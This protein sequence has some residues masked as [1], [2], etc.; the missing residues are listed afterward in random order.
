MKAT[1]KPLYGHLSIGNDVFN[2]FSTNRNI[3]LL[4]AES[5]EKKRL[6]M[7][8]RAISHETEL[9]EFL[10]GYTN[11]RQIAILR[12]SEFQK[13]FYDFAPSL[14]FTTPMI[15]E[16]A[17]YTEE[18]FSPLAE[19]W[20][21]FHAITFKGI[22]LNNLF[23]PYEALEQKS[24]QERATTDGVTDLKTLP[25][26]KYT[27]EGSA[28]IDG[29][30]IAYTISIAQESLPPL[31]KDHT[32]T[33][34]ELN[35]FIRFSFDEPQDFSRITRYFLIAKS[36]ISLLTMQNNVDFETYLS[37][38]N[39]DGTYYRTANC[40]IYD[41]YEN[42]ATRNQYRVIP[43]KT[44]RE[45]IPA[46]LENIAAGKYEALFTILPDDNRRL[47]MISITNIQDLC[48]ALEVAYKWGKNQR[49]KDNIIV[50][51]RKEAAKAAIAALQKEYPEI[52]LK[53]ETTIEKTFE[54]LDFIVKSKIFTLYEENQR[55]IDT[56]AK[57]HNWETLTA[58]RISEFTSI[59]NKKT[60]AGTFEWG[61][62]AE[63]YPLLYALAYTCALK[64]AGISEETLHQLIWRLF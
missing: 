3:L 31:G 9:P 56:L 18:F 43:I 29:Q 27:M 45:Q 40:R 47:E 35:T 59:R 11:A 60:H 41:I 23:T 37:Q 22:N 58:E 49:K 63:I 44:I 55:I 20:N 54:Y 28:T 61:A 6:D 2:Y 5:D 12:S 52:A 15:V 14:A 33:L 10:F 1:S 42:Y 24:M 53:Q 39:A 13:N 34:G 7:I 57:K 25:W 48:T 64:Q 36:F 8:E 30:S 46:I 62:V 19:A 17:G 4:P 32:F 50:P 16:A 26:N 38:R 51:I 21:K